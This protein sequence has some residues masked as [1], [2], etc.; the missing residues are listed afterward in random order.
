M[1]QFDSDG[2]K[3]ISM[4]MAFSRSNPSPR[5]IELQ[6]QYRTMHEKGESFLGIPPEG[7]FP[8]TSLISQAPSIKRMIDLTGARSI[9][10]Y[11][12]GKGMQYR[13]GTVRDESTGREWPSIQ[14]YWGVER[15][16][17][18]DPCYPP[19]SQLPVGRFDGV[20]CT[21]VLEH[22]PELDIPWIVDEIFHFASQ[23]VFANVACYPA[24]KRL[25]SGEN[26]HC[27]IRP[28]QWWKELFGNVASKYPGTKWEVWIQHVSIKPQGQTIVEERIGNV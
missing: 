28:Q 23:F 14:E 6:S 21:D 25:P 22:C 9:L 16:V 1:A 18:Y 4:T 10:D 26:A 12:S 3:S 11:G 24:K 20:I 19:F 5:Y 13:P 2:S 7:T 17:C 15:I 8:G 27:T